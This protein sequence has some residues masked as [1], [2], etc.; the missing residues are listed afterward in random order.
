MAHD[1]HVHVVS[2]LPTRRLPMNIHAQRHVHSMPM[3]RGMCMHRARISVLEA[4]SLTG[5]LIYAVQSSDHR[6]GG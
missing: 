3:S 5:R 4:R 1:S 6:L 2:I